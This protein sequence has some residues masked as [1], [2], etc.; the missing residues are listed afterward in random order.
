[1]AAQLKSVEFVYNIRLG[2]R[3]GPNGSEE[4]R[5]H[6]L[7]QTTCVWFEINFPTM[8][9]NSGSYMNLDYEDSQKYRIP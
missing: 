6:E 1:M 5:N 4:N 7:P 3:G 9:K 8:E 2:G